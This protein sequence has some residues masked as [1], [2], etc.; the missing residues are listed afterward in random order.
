M[1]GAKTVEQAHDCLQPGTGAATVTETAIR[2]ED[3]ATGEA[4]QIESAIQQHWEHDY[5]II[6]LASLNGQYFA[7]FQKLTR[8]ERQTWRRGTWEQ[9]NTAIKEHWAKGYSITALSRDRDRWFVV[10]SE[11]LDHS[12]HTF[13][14]PTTTTELKSEI[15]AAWNDEYG[16]TSVA[17]H[18]GA[19][20]VVLSQGSVNR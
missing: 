11:D 18:P 9:V 12:K 3:T 16:I 15:A 8:I 20:V 2:V 6:D 4:E 10:L 5:R 1:T 13:R 19:W 7:L 14:A 17:G